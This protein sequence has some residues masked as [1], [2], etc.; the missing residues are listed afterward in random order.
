MDILFLLLQ[1]VGL[2]VVAVAIWIIQSAIV[3]GFCRRAIYP[4]L[5]KS[6]ITTWLIAH[7]SIIFHELAHFAL[8]VATGSRI[9]VKES[10]ITPTTGRIA[11]IHEESIFGW[12]S[13]TFAAIA[14]CIVAPC[15]VAALTI[16]LAQ[17]F[18]F[19]A[20]V[21]IYPNNYEELLVRSSVGLE[22]LASNLQIFL[23]T[24]TNLSTPLTFFLIYIAI[25]GTISAGPS[26]GDW[27]AVASLLF[28]PIPALSLLAFAGVFSVGFAAFGYGLFVPLVTLFT[29][30]LIVTVVGIALA[31]VFSNFISA[32][33]KIGIYALLLLLLFATTYAYLCITWQE[34]GTPLIFLLSL[35]PPLLAYPIILY[36]KSQHYL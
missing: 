7:P 28:S 8:V 12:T 18:R 11:A 25:I 27:Q 30:L 3:L 36:A 4:V 26:A 20:S 34:G 13:R 1:I 32:C 21:L 31:F 19:D 6:A 17:Q 24:I 14:P 33:H 15:I 2:F 10:F 5:Y 16:V 9:R 35:C 23:N 29:F 22:L